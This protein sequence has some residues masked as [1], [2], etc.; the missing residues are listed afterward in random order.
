[1]KQNN[2]NIVYVFGASDLD[3]A[4]E[5]E[6]AVVG[7]NFEITVNDDPSPVTYAKA[8]VSG[9]HVRTF[10][11]ND[12]VTAY[13]GVDEPLWV[14]GGDGVDIVIGGDSGDS[15]FGGSGNDTLSGG[16]GDDC[17][18]GR[19]GNDQ[20]NGGDGDDEL[21]GGGGNDI[22]NGGD[23]NDVLGGNGGQDTLNGE[24]GDDVLEG[25][26]D[27]DVLL[28][29]SGFDGP[30]VVDNAGT[31]WAPSSGWSSQSMEAAFNGS[32]HMYTYS[33]TAGQ[34]TWT[35]SGLTGTEDAW[36]GVF[37]TWA[38]DPSLTTTSDAPFMISVDGNSSYPV[39]DID[40]RAAPVGDLLE[41]RYWQHL[42]TVCV[43]TGTD[44]LDVRLDSVAT[45]GISVLADAIRLVPYES[46][47]LTDIAI[48][49][50]STD[51]SGDLKVEYDITGEGA[52]PFDIGVYSSLD[53][54]TPVTLLTSERISV[55]QE[56]DAS[57][58]VTF[59]ANLLDLDDDHVLI[60]K[61]D[62]SLEVVETNESNNQEQFTGGI[63]DSTYGIM[64]VQGTDAET[65]QRDTVSIS[66]DGDYLNVSLNG[67]SLSSA[68]LMEDVC[69][70]HIRT[71][72][73]NDQ[74]TVGAGVTVPIMAF[75]GAGDDVL[76]GG[77]SDDELYGGDGVD[78][79]SG[80]AGNDTLYGGDGADAITGGAG[81][82][83]ICGEGD[84]D[85]LLSGGEGDD[86][87]HGGAGNDTVEGGAGNDTIYG[88]DGADII[89]GESGDDHIH[90]GADA[91]IIDG[92]ANGD[93]IYGG[94]GM[95]SIDGDDGDDTVFGGDEPAGT[96]GDTILGG[97]GNDEI[98]GGSGEDD[99]QGGIG[100]DWLFGDG[101]VDSISGGDGNDFI[102]GGTEGDDLDGDAGRDVIRGGAGDDQI[103][104][105]AGR[106]A[107]SGGEGA[108]T[109][110]GGADD[111]W[112]GGDGGDDFL[113]GDAG[114][115]GGQ[116]ND[117][118]VGGAG[119]DYLDGGDGDDE[120]YG[121]DGDDELYGQGGD[122][123]LDDA[124]G[125]P[126]TD[127][128]LV[129]GDGLDSL[130]QIID[131]TS[132]PFHADG[133]W[134]A[135]QNN[136]GYD[137]SFSYD[138]D[139]TAGEYAEWVFD[140][141]QADVLYEVFATWPN[142]DDFTGLTWSASASYSIY[143]DGTGGAGLVGTKSV[144]QSQDEP[145]VELYDYLWT[146]L[147]EWTLDSD[148]LRVRLSDDPNGVVCADAIIVRPVWITLDLATDSNN[149]GI[150]DDTLGGPDD[151][152]EEGSPGRIVGVWDASR[153][154]VEIDLDLHGYGL[155]GGE[156]L[157][158]DFLGDDSLVR[159]WDAATNGTQ[160]NT[161]HTWA[162]TDDIETTVYVEGIGSGTS[163]F[164]LTLVNGPAGRPLPDSLEIRVVEIDG[165]TR[166]LWEPGDN[167][168]LLPDEEQ[169][170]L[171][172]TIR[173]T[174]K[175]LDPD[176]SP[177]IIDTTWVKRPSE[178]AGDPD[179]P[180]ETF[181]IAAGSSP[182][183]E[184]VRSSLELG[185]WEITP[186]VSFVGGAVAAMVAADPATGDY[187]I[188]GH[189]REVYGLQVYWAN[190]SH[191]KTLV[192][193]D[194]FL[195][196]FGGGHAIYPEKLQPGDRLQIPDDE[197]ASAEYLRGYKFAKV[198]VGLNARVKTGTVGGS[199]RILDPSHYSRTW[200]F[201]IG[202]GGPADANT[203]DDNEG[204][205]EVLEY[206][207][208]G[209]HPDG[210]YYRGLRPPQNKR[211]GFSFDS[212]TK[213]PDQ[214]TT[215]HFN[216]WVGP[217]DD[218]VVGFQATSRSR[219]GYDTTPSED[220]P[221]DNYIV[222][223]GRVAHVGSVSFSTNDGCTPEWENEAGI[224]V[225]VPSDARTEVLTVVRT[226]Y[227]ESDHMTQP[228]L[229]QTPHPSIYQSGAVITPQQGNVVK[230]DPSSTYVD[231]KDAHQ[232]K[233]GSITL[234]QGSTTLGTYT[235]QDNTFEAP[236]GGGALIPVITL[237][238]TPPAGADRY[239][240]LRDDDVL[241]EAA[242][243]SPNLAP[244]A[245]ILQMGHIKLDL[246]KHDLSPDNDGTVN[247]TDVEFKVNIGTNAHGQSDPDVYPDTF[248]EFA[249]DIVGDV[250]PDDPSE[251]IPG[252]RQ[253]VIDRDF[254][255]A[256]ILGA[257]QPTLVEDGDHPD[258]GFGVFFVPGLTIPVVDPTVVLAGNNT[259]HFSQT[260]ASFVFRE[261]ARDWA[262][263]LG[264]DSMS[265]DDLWAAASTHEILHQF[266]LQDPFRGKPNHGTIM[267]IE[268]VAASDAELSTLGVNRDGYLLIRANYR[269]GA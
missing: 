92:G 240:D 95:D 190:F 72:E 142:D 212:I 108:D 170:L 180:W 99:I 226:L 127:N 110:Y 89:D 214:P 13:T 143:D 160:I 171:D 80:N 152:C 27:A 1:L 177:Y 192:G 71:H 74:L 239:V 167:W 134:E 5:V 10:G 116:G 137:N 106:D 14:F 268:E 247:Q 136:G 128:L 107:I 234:K 32:Q 267:D 221:T 56:G 200:N 243:M 23:D 24:A 257:Y 29:G 41:E 246:K 118:L 70:V 40:Q 62:A 162:V 260:E 194:Q 52:P 269:P 83:S 220:M 15:L 189:N 124:L 184:P 256:Y 22:L 217:W 73:G 35:F 183:V 219:T 60:A 224:T 57:H 228:D 215:R 102:D 156:Y 7:E 168:E 165:V 147:G 187:E 46:E 199:V 146:K 225:A 166:E 242:D 235:I 68:P 191:R 130:E 123:L 79:I 210:G 16:L 28:G 50:F 237:T 182:A 97:S 195:K 120:L 75:G 245:R 86:H 216:G 44:T 263:H 11:A 248:R 36:Y 76:A 45:T 53:G 151:A 39:Q 255:V 159:V 179:Y 47:P 213:D 161:G 207:I 54:V 236:Q 135:P 150:L 131:D 244:L 148:E 176:L 9:F 222:V 101:D 250:D 91:D 122:D 59:C 202:N 158:L 20:L 133:Y 19:D 163:T 2:D 26:T 155:V 251:F 96:D 31:Q 98:H 109:A 145:D 254:W 249:Q 4:E 81:D 204:N 164:T 126:S 193:Y 227:V 149:D 12:T 172:D 58:E 208:D 154:P 198:R 55:E 153:T 262:V 115:S 18:F 30:E 111:D 265:E 113:Y 43:P 100:D 206:Q 49:G 114:V 67:T 186:L 25:G 69:L 185:Y 259:A 229:L 17:L 94:T 64:Y 231:G 61:V 112:L 78:T 233:G 77:D 51:A 105:G 181:A 6:I 203:W 21:Y 90:G 266:G 88:Q 82:D 230:L 197:E 85:T 141:L 253:S 104:G 238:E 178:H 173:W 261:T 188:E 157:Q 232:L 218:I 3:V 38:E 125:N 119:D 201:A 8:D 65:G 66:A 223:A 117:V 174:A 211:G 264:E 84:A 63:F 138:G 196:D 139:P 93:T 34:A 205:L 42:N 103:D 121:G 144:N 129:G 252:T 209:R 169:L 48:T 241:C 87:I 175:G 33:G 140:G 258:G 132:T 37:A